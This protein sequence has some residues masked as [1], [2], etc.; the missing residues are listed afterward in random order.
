MLACL[1]VHITL[2][3]P[4]QTI[5]ISY[6]L[7][8]QNE[9]TKDCDHWS[10]DRTTVLTYA[11]LMKMIL[12]HRSTKCY[13]GDTFPQPCTKYKQACQP[14]FYGSYMNLGFEMYFTF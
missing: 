13:K 12:I 6:Q 11:A 2:H 3:N 1:F 7:N 8:C 4:I 5:V 9:C 10:L 14:S